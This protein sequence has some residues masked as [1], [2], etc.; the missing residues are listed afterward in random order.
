MKKIIAVI[1]FLATFSS[2]SFSQQTGTE[3]NTK[4]HGLFHRKDAVKPR[5][6]KQHFERQTVDKSAMKHNGTA[7]S[8]RRQERRMRKN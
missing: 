8:N 7:A 5:E 3:I 1:L 2:A 6:Q 4:K